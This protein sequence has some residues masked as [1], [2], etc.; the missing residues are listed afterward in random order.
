MLIGGLDVGSTGC[1][2][3]VY[4][5]SGT[6]VCNAYREYEINRKNGA[7]EIDPDRIFDAV[8]E[9]IRETVSQHALSA[10]GVTSFGESFVALDEND[11]VLLPSMLYTDPRGG[12][13]CEL[14]C[15]RLGEQRLIELAGVKPHAMYSLPKLMWIQQNRPDVY[16]R[17]CRVLLI[18]DYIVYRLSGSA[19]IDHSLAART[20]AFDI[21]K[22][23]WCREILD[24]A[25]V[26]VE[27]FSIPVHAGHVAG[28]LKREL[29][30]RLGVK[31]TVQIVNGS[32]DQV[33]ATVGA[34]IFCPG[35]AMDGTGTVECIVPVFDHIPTDQSLYREGYSVVPYVF[36]GTYVCYAFSF[37]GGAVLKWF[38][39]SF[40]QKDGGKYSYAEL[41]ASVPTDPTGILVLPH[42]A[43]AANPYMDNGSRAAI[44]GLS[45][46]HGRADLYKAMME[47]VTYEIMTNLEHLERF[48]IKPTRLYATGGGAMSEVWLGIKADILGRP[49]VALDAGEVGAAG[50]C[51]LTGVG[52][53]LYRNLAEAK[54]YF[55]RERKTCLPDPNR[56]SRYR[57]SYRAYR[58]LYSAVRPIVE[59]GQDRSVWS[60][61]GV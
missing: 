56:A 53:G 57:Q 51:M 33:A 2:L 11:R 25:G 15:K 61:N 42:F 48:G 28:E 60:K 24:A 9:V 39:D 46:E 8:C 26:P 20:M 6:F 40:A 21:R 23:E 7:H 50:T 32:H 34:G 30:D 19:C 54:Q 27:W 47:G 4:D 52:I 45:L 22:R 36:E 14:L 18:E 41:D 55:V 13:E 16:Q 17:I 37:T 58:N 10:I 1:K 38:R 49:V 43:G 35:E 31:G 5:A 29:A 3:S 12:E 44:V 59:Q